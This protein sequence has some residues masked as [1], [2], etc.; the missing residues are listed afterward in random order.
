MPSQ[1]SCDFR[2]STRINHAIADVLDFDRASPQIYFD[3]EDKFRKGHA[4][5][6]GYVPTPVTCGPL[7]DMYEQL[8]GSLICQHTRAAD[9][10][11]K[12]EQE[13]RGAAGE[14]ARTRAVNRFR[15]DLGF[16]SSLCVYHLIGADSNYP[17]CL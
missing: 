10:H 15:R 16:G 8:C 4:I 9:T 6:A 17:R 5:V 7:I 1:C 2:Q 11:N 14:F 13:E 12:V 3:P